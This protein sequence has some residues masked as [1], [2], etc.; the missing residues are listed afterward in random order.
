MNRSVTFSIVLAGLVAGLASVYGCGGAKPLAFGNA[1][2]GGGG[3]SLA[4]S[5]AGAAGQSMADAGGAD[6]AGAG[7]ADTAGVGGA[8]TAGSGA[9]GTDDA[10]AGGTGASGAT[11]AGLG[12]G[13]GDITKVVPTPGCGHDPGQA[14][15]V[16]VMG[17]IDTMGTKPAGCADTKCGAW[18]Y[19]RQYFLTLPAGYDKN[20]AYPLIIETPTCGGFTGL[21]VYSLNS[22]GDDTMPAHNLVDNTV[23]RVG[24]TPPP[25]AGLNPNSSD[26]F[27]NADGDNSVDWVFYENLYDRLAE[28]LCFDR[29][30]VF[31]AGE[32]RGGPILTEL[33]CKYAGDATRPVRGVLADEGGLAFSDAQLPTCTGK[34][35]AGIWIHNTEDPSMPFA[36]A[37]VAIAR[38]MKA[39]GCTIGTGFD[40]AQFDD[41]PIGGG[42]P[43]TTCE[44]IKGCP[45]VTPLVVCPVPS[46]Q[47]SLHPTVANPGFSTFI[48]LFETAPLLTP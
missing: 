34:P 8:G 40:D 4:G 9:A 20:K 38:A 47:S 23:I 22:L 31:A 46:N 16:A 12:F 19:I 2:S 11:G 44:K 29:N 7:G 18:M 17:T 37:K 3:G 30:R 41:F 28:Q 45:D 15:N 36:R 25:A 10:A 14:I 32:R 48:E 42:N 35:T 13:G 21:E 24:L 1:G 33:G 26:C 6:T 43:A 39:N 27:D 5:T